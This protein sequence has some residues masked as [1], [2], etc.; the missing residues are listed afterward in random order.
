MNKGWVTAGCEGIE[1]GMLVLGVLPLPLFLLAAMLAG[2]LIN[3]PSAGAVRKGEELTFISPPEGADALERGALSR[4][5]YSYS[6]VCARN[7]SLVL[8]HPQ[9]QGGRENQQEKSHFGDDVD[10]AK[11]GVAPRIVSL[12]ADHVEKQITKL[13]QRTAGVNDAHAVLSS[14]VALFRTRVHGGN[15]LPATARWMGAAVGLRIKFRIAAVTGKHVIELRSAA[16]GVP[17]IGIDLGDLDDRGKVEEK[18]SAVSA[19][20]EEKI[21]GWLVFIS[22]QHAVCKR[23]QVSASGIA[24]AKNDLQFRVRGRIV[25]AGR[26]HAPEFELRR[27]VL[28]NL[29]VAPA[30]YFQRRQQR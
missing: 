1:L 4:K 23:A 11:E 20:A 16:P 8:G 13:A 15:Q 9:A 18:A 25:F 17:R 5:W 6:C 28:A 30:L 21:R 24:L 19:G 26:R 14:R 10:F 22:R 27:G 12:G 29:A 2:R 3:I 7:N